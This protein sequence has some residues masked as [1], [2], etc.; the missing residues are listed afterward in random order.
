MWF[1]LCCVLRQATLYCMLDSTDGPPL[2]AEVSAFTAV[3]RRTPEGAGAN[4]MFAY[5]AAYLC[6]CAACNELWC[7]LRQATR[8]RQPSTLYPAQRRSVRSATL[9]STDALLV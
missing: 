1:G 2:R 8:M 7:R 9:D 3:R 6:V 5:Y 4:D